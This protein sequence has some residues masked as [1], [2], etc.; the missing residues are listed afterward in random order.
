MAQEQSA[1]VESIRGILSVKTFGQEDTRQRLWQNR[2]AEAVNAKLRM[3]QT[4]AGFDAAQNAILGFETIAF[5]FVAIGL[6]MDAQ[7]T[8]G[9][10]FAF[11]SFKMHFLGAGTRLIQTAVDW[12]LN[13]VHLNRIADIALSE[14]E[15]GLLGAGVDQPMLTGR[16]E[17][18]NIGWRYGT[19][20]PLVLQQVNLTIEPGETVLLI[21]PSGGGKTTLMK[22]MLG[23]LDPPVGEVLVDGMPLQSYGK[24][25][26]RRQD[27][28]EHRLLRHPHRHGPSPCGSQEGGDRCGHPADAHGLRDAGWRHGFQ[29]VG[30]AA[31][32]GDD[33]A[34]ALPAT[35]HCIC[36]RDHGLSRPC[37]P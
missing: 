16:I 21:G 37:Q 26:F 32:A 5:T 25:G 9:M 29:P 7:F 28:G 36:R 2:L 34:R 12:R 20:E 33:C 18:R 14:P 4:T 11:Q 15:R 17:L 13:G 30:R 3:A 31:P 23:L 19:G 1:L 22:I 35:S 24:A 10:L 8:V 27:R 6:V